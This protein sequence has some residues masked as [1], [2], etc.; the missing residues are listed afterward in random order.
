MVLYVGDM[1]ATV[2]E[3]R[4]LADQVAPHG[5]RN[6]SKDSKFLDL[7]VQEL[8]AR[9]H[10]FLE[11]RRRGVEK[12]QFLELKE[13]AVAEQWVGFHYRT[14]HLEGRFPVSD[15]EVK[16]RLPPSPE[17]A[18]VREIVVETREEALAV[19]QELKAGKSFE[20]IA[21]DRSISPSAKN[22]GKLGSRFLRGRSDL[23]E[24]AVQDRFFT[25]GAGEVIPE[26]IQTPMGFSV[27]RVEERTPLSADERKALEESIR[28]DIREERF[29][30]LVSKFKERYPLV[31]NRK[32]LE[33]AASDPIGH[34]D[35]PIA[36]VGKNEVRFGELYYFV[37]AA[38]RVGFKPKAM[39][40][41][42]WESALGSQ[43]GNLLFRE[44]AAEEGLLDSKPV[45]ENL[46][47]YHKFVVLE[48]F[49][50]NL[51][52]DTKVS[53]G[54]I[55][56][57]YEEMKPEWRKTRWYTV[58]MIQLPTRREA[59]AAV[60]RLRAGKS[61][62]GIMPD[63][64]HK[65][66]PGGKTEIP[67]RKMRE[68]E[69]PVDIRPAVVRM[70]PGDVGEPVAVSGQGKVAGYLVFRLDDVEKGKI[71]QLGEVRKALEERLRTEKI[72]LATTEISIRMSKTVG[73][74]ELNRPL[75]EKVVAEW[76]AKRSGGKAG[77]EG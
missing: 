3:V 16:K 2:Q 64:M 50:E 27:I 42:D 9:N 22:G 71:P 68:E 19:L 15:D 62:E 32:N 40:L 54:E 75:L 31:T 47:R 52:R 55:R 28:A 44:A 38:E 35:L 63:F 59:Q 41:N 37:E 45:R 61:L 13:K 23:F 26:P 14:V 34:L 24:K 77:T 65:V 73:M 8:V 7:L 72:R 57:R 56:K 46:L 58:T 4:D 70:K 69:I 10:L 12:A 60:S 21:R 6:L 18:A 39:K 66:G 43:Y 17:W 20:G 67:S 36:S 48:K 11:A 76:D 74:R 53:D 29:G 5:Q 51:K 30:A 25:V 1:P 33:K 49:R